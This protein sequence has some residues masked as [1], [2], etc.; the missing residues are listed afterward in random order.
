MN[1]RK[2]VFCFLL[3]ILFS[4]ITC[5][6]ESVTHEY[7]ELILKSIQGIKNEWAQLYSQNEEWYKDG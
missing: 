3:L 5:I 7:D 2:T 1:L 4:N 6:A